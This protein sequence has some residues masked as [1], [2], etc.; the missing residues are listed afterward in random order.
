MERLTVEEI[1]GHCNRSLDK[2]PSGSKLYQE[3]ESTR[4]Y[5]QMLRHYI[6]LGPI[7]HLRELVGQGRMGKSQN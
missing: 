1:I 2:I 3:H 6:A 5:L 4:A 7:D